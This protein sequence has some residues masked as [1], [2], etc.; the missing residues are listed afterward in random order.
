MFAIAA[1][2]IIA[3]K[4]IASIYAFLLHIVGDPAGRRRH[5]QRHD[6]TANS[7]RKYGFLC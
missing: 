1:C 2:L 3:I 5:G 7:S 4:V 6:S